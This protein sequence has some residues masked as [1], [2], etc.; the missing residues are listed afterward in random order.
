MLEKNQLGCSNKTTTVA[1]R[2][3]VGRANIKIHSKHN[4]ESMVDDSML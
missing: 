4:I 3:I 2:V 1:E